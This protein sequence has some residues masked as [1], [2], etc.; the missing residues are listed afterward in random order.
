MP[1][2]ITI[3]SLPGNSEEN[4]PYLY[5]NTQDLKLVADYTRL[6]FNELL[7]LDCYTFK[8]LVK[9]AFIH[10]MRQTPDGVEYLENCWLLCQTKPDRENLRKHF[11]KGG[12]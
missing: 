6:N 7:E 5:T 3:P 2:G 1:G 9:D 11:S 8:Y 10:Q 4:K 12:S